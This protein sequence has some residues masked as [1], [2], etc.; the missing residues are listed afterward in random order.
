M[1]RVAA[2]TPTTGGVTLT[3][4]GLTGLKKFVVK[5]AAG[6]VLNGSKIS[7]TS[8]TSAKVTLPALPAGDYSIRVFAISATGSTA[9]NF[10][11]GTPAPATPTVSRART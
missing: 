6:K 2:P 4:T 8:A 1:D 5:N 3:G 11:V 7:V 10:T 9:F